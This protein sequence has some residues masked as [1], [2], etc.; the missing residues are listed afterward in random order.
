VTLSQSGKPSSA[1]GK[2]RGDKDAPSIR[3]KIQYQ[4]VSIEPI[5]VY[6]ELIKVS[7]SYWWH[8]LTHVHVPV[9]PPSE[10]CLIVRSAISIEFFALFLHT[11]SAQLLQCGL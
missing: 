6:D 9:A 4:V 5:K 8:S 10:L 11:V 7:T 1:A 2:E 3:F